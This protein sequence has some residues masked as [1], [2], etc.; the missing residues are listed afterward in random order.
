M[1]A[2]ELAQQISSAPKFRGLDIKVDRDTVRVY[3]FNKT[4]DW[5]IVK[6]ALEE[7][8]FRCGPN[9]GSLKC[10]SEPQPT[11]AERISAQSP[12]EQEKSRE[13]WD[14]MARGR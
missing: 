12:E 1:K 2:N 14:E 9:F 4:P 6:S 8:G 5:Q 11:L 10:D 7:M 3:G 13:L